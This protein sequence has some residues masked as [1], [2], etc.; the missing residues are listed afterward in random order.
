MPK[1]AVD[2]IWRYLDLIN[3][4][5]DNKCMHTWSEPMWIGHAI[6]FIGETLKIQFTVTFFYAF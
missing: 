3:N 5:E 4:M 1:E 6:S 2:I